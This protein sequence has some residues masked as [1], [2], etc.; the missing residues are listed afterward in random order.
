[1][2]VGALRK[3]VNRVA[4]DSPSPATSG[5]LPT[6]VSAAAPTSACVHADGPDGHRSSPNHREPVFGSVFT[7]THLPVTGMQNSRDPALQRSTSLPQFGPLTS[8][9]KS[10]SGESESGNFRSR[11][12]VPKVNFPVFMGDNPKLW[13]S[14]C[15]DYFGLYNIEPSDWIKISSMHFTESAARWL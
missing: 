12:R 14:R 9:S 4:L 15:K 3:T 5:I 7:H 10:R 13:I 11:G 1:M 6:P 2:E 8:G